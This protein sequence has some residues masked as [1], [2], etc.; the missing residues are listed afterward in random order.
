MEVFLPG[1][2]ADLVRFTPTGGLD[3]TLNGTG[4]ATLS[5]LPGAGAYQATAA[6]ALSDGSFAVAGVAPD[7]RARLAF[8]TQDGQLELG[9]LADGAGSTEFQLAP[10]DV[11]DSVFAVAVTPDGG[12][13]VAGAAGSDTNNTSY[14]AALA[15]FATAPPTVMLPLALDPTFGT[16]GLQPLNAG[17]FVE[18]I[19]AAPDGRVYTA[20][21]TSTGYYIEATN[22]DGTPDTGF[23]TGGAVNVESLIPPAALGITNHFYLYNVYALPDGGLLVLGGDLPFF[24]SEV[25]VLK[26]TRSGALD[27]S[28]GTG[29]IAQFASSTTHMGTA[30][31]L[32]VDAAGKILIVGQPDFTNAVLPQDPGFSVLRLNPDGS[33]D[34]TFNGT[35]T[36]FIPAV[37]P[38][39]YNGTL[40]LASLE[41]ATSVAVRPN[42]QILV[43][44]NLLPADATAPPNS[45]ATYPDLAVAQLNPDGS[46]D[47][48]FGTNGVVL[49]STV[50]GGIGDEQAFL[51]PDGRLNVTTPA[52]NSSA[53]VLVRF[54]AAGALDTTLNGTGSA[55]IVG[56]TAAPI[57]GDSDFVAAG[58]VPDPD[59]R[60]VVEVYDQNGSPVP[61][62]FASGES[63]TL[64]AFAASDPENGVNAITVT[65]DGRVIVAGIAKA[66]A[67]DGSGQ[68]TLA[69]FATAPLVVPPTPPPVAP[70]P[71]TLPLALDPTFGTGGVQSVGTGS[72][73]FGV[74][75]ASNGTLY[76]AESTSSG[77]RIVATNPDG[78]SDTGFGTGG[79]VDVESLFPPPP[80]GL[81]NTVVLANIY[82]ESDGKL[83]VLENIPS[84]GDAFQLVRL[85]AD[86]SL[87][88]TFGAGGR[89]VSSLYTPVFVTASSLTIQPDG[90]VLVVGTPSLSSGINSQAGFS[91]VR[92]NPD[93]SPDATFNQTGYQ[94][95]PAVSSFSPLAQTDEG[96]QTAVVRPNGQILVIGSLWPAGPAP[97][98]PVPDGA[99]LAVVQLNSDGSVD[100]TFGTGGLTVT[101]FVANGSGAGEQ[102]T[103]LADGR[104]E[105]FLPGLTSSLVRLTPDGNL[106]TTLGGNGSVAIGQNTDFGLSLQPYFSGSDLIVAGV[107]ANNQVD[108][109]VY[110]QNGVPVPDAFAAGGS[111]TTF[112]FAPSDPVNWVDTITV[113]PDGR[114]IVA[115]VARANATDANGQLTLAAFATSPP[116][117]PPFPRYRSSPPF[118]QYRSRH[119]RS[120][121]P[122]IRPGPVASS[123]RISLRAILP[124]NPA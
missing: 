34:T 73:V 86:G 108:V 77:E 47:T 105:V 85:N 94:F 102:A 7:G 115:G 74:A 66:S 53:G 51:L 26:L 21:E 31:G 14:Q 35:G 44:G 46:L 110:D 38:A 29:G 3:T 60:V 123:R 72:M 81:L 11:L 9:S 19:S 109:S 39:P 15:A 1:S 90:K 56:P 83:L 50:I 12:I 122:S 36:Q 71:V 75:T 70:P 62:A 59:G 65:P 2:T 23:G 54:T 106:D 55:P 58:V 111:S 40:F 114:L 113:T 82:A 13:L 52:F 121:L 6:V 57:N 61:D 68:P 17:L 67:T 42:G 5:L 28:F 95:V 124:A 116:I 10:G 92:L 43:I 33:L 101:P 98:N 118:L 20:A 76:T 120:R 69:A 87:D 45:A 4:E 100:T 25:E 84:P 27:T 8:F 24:G 104:L 48:T 78:S 99:N 96:A 117:A 112:S 107:D 119:R 32:T 18:G 30:R 16:G 41:G 103:L 80:G 97:T 64:F 91:I 88:A 22:P 89:V 63:A 37:N 49:S 93:G 79:T